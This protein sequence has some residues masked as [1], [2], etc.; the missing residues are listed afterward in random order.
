VDFTHTDVLDRGERV[1]RRS[2]GLRSGLESHVGDREMTINDAMKALAEKLEPKPTKHPRGTGRQTLAWSFDDEMETENNF[3][4][5]MKGWRP[6]DFL[7]SEDASARLLEAMK[8][9]CHRVDITINCKWD[10]IAI[11]LFPKAVK[12]RPV[13]I[14]SKGLKLSNAV[15]LAALAWK[16]IERPEGL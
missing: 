14:V 3:E 11:M 5:V 16:G 7:H 13:S 9:D 10:E 4:W 2:S 6:I 1:L 8:D 12:Q 15:F